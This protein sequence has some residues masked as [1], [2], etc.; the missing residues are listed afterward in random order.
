MVI[1]TNLESMDKSLPYLMSSK[2]FLFRHFCRPLTRTLMKIKLSLKNSLN[3]AQLETKYKHESGT[4]K[5][6]RF[7]YFTFD[8]YCKPKLLK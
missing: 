1:P 7:R 5:K 2:I 8:S 4:D 6:L 3:R